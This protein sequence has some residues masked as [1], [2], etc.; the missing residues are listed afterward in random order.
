VNFLNENLM[1]LLSNGQPAVWN[2]RVAEQCNR[3]CDK[4]LL[5]A[6]TKVFRRASKSSKITVVTEYLHRS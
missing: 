6:E 4:N 1:H 5:F 3:W 2:D